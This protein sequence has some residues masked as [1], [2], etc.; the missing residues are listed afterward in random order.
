MSLRFL[1]SD[2]PLQRYLE[3]KAEIKRLYAELKELQPLILA[4]LFEEPHQ[5]TTYQGFELTIGE[6]R[7]WDYSPKVKALQDELKALKKHEEST[8]LAAIKRHT[9]FVIA[10]AAKDD[11][12]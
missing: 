6:R 11:L 7:T 2:A 10:R 3:L 5:Q 9:S 8:G 4:A 12:K 1:D